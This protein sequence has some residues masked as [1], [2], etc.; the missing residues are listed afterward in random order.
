MCPLIIDSLINSFFKSDHLTADLVDPMKLETMIE[1]KDLISLK[2]D[3]YHETVADMFQNRETPLVRTYH[4]D[5]NV[6]AVHAIILVG[7]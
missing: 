7:F 3:F 5:Q 2:S 1:G 6:L 4:E